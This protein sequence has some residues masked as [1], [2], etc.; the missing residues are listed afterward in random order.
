MIDTLAFYNYL[1]DNSIDF[2]AGVPDS[3][4]A[5]FC[6]CIKANCRKSKNII[7]ANEGNAVAMAAGYHISTGKIGCVYMQNSGEGNA[8]NPLLSL[9]DEDV[10]SIPM[11]LI[12]GWRGQPGKHDEPQHVKQGKVTCSLL[13]AMG[14]R[15]VVLSDNYKDELQAA[16]KYMNEQNSPF[17]LV[18]QK[19]LFGPYKMEKES[20]EYALTREDALKEIISRL[21]QDDVIVSTTGKTSREIFEI[22]EDNKQGHSN[23]FLTVGSMGHTASIAYGIAIGTDRNVWCI[24]GDGSL[25]MHM[26]SL[27]VIGS[28][29][30][31]N[32][33]YIVN[34]NNAHESVGGQPTCS[35]N[36]D[37][38]A[39]LKACG[40]KDVIVAETA[41][42]IR[43]G[44]ERLKRESG[45]AMVLHTKQGSRA[46][47][48]RPTTTPQ[49]NKK[50]LMKKL[51]AIK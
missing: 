4:L 40:F 37:I 50:A 34:D 47:L 51:G 7:T 39:I 3:L 17:A 38:P 25:I 33:K 26:G 30:P 5:D 43:A 15:Y 6:A 13:D 28:D 11:L 48:G 32:F 2:F 1:A 46:D 20:S 22:R 16:I 9:A 44:I 24:D 19:G 27:G 12:I 18:V 29:I 14:I 23:D 42:Q 31:D 8:V 21:T 45:V 41:E 36:I 10:Y 35:K 49:E